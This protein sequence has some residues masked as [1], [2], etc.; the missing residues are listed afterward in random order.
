LLRRREDGRQDVGQR[1][2]EERHECRRGLVC[3]F[4]NVR[5]LGSCQVENYWQ[6]RREVRL[7]SPT[8]EAQQIVT[9]RLLLLTLP[10]F[11]VS[12]LQRIHFR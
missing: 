11:I 5:E 8:A 4:T 2:R 12:R 3:R 6:E 7:G 9:T 10:G 1:R